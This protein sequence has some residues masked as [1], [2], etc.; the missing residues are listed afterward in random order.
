[1]NL[2]E[3]VEVRNFTLLEVLPNRHGPA[4]IEALSRM[5]AKLKYLGL[6]VRRVHSDAAGELRSTKKWCHSHGLYRTFTAGSDWMANGRAEAEIGMVRRGINVLMRLPEAEEEDWPLMARHVAER[7]GRLQLEGMGFSTPTLLPWNTQ[8]VVSTKGWDEFQGHW[9]PRKR[10]GRVRGPDMSMSLTSGGHYILLEDGKHVRASEVVEVTPE[11]ETDVSREAQKEEVEVQQTDRGVGPMSLDGRPA[12]RVGEKTAIKN[13][14]CEDLQE[15]LDRGVQFANELFKTCEGAGVEVPGSCEVVVPMVYELDRENEQLEIFIK[16]LRAAEAVAE[17]L[18]CQKAAE[19]N[20]VL[21]TKTFGLNEVRKELPKWIPALEKEVDSILSNQAVQRVSLPEAEKYMEEMRAKGHFVERVPGKAVFTQKA[22]SGRLKARICVCGNL[23]SERAAEDLYASGVDSTQVRTLVRKAAMEQWE[24]ASLDIQTAFLLAPTSQQELIVMTPP[25]ILVEAKLV[26]ADEVWIITSA[27]YGM[28][29]APRDWANY[30]D[31][32]V[33]SWRWCIED[34]DGQKCSIQFRPLGDQ[35][36]WGV[37]KKGHDKETCEG[38]AAFYVDDILMTGPKEVCD[39][40]IQQIRSVWGT[41]TPE[42]VEEGRAMKFLGIEI[43]KLR[44]GEILLHQRCYT[45]EL[46]N[47][48]GTILKSPTLKLPEEPEELPVVKTEDIRLAQAVTGELQWLANN[49]RPDIAVFVSRMA[50]L[51]TKNPRWVVEAGQA[52]LAYLAATKDQGLVYGKLEKDDADVQRRVPREAG[53]VEVMCDASF[54]VNDQHSITGIMILY[55]GGAVHWDTRKQT[56]VALSTAEAELTA[57]VD[58][59]QAG[60]SVRALVDL[61][62][63]RTTMEVANDNRAALVLGSGQ[64]GGWRT[65]HLRIRA[66]CVSEAVSNG[67]IILMH[68]PGSHLWADALTKVLPPALLERFKTG[69]KL[70]DGKLMTLDRAETANQSSEAKMRM[71]KALTAMTVAASLPKG[72]RA[73]DGSGG[74]EDR[75]SDL[76]LLMLLGGLLVIYELVKAFGIHS[77]K[78]LWV[79]EDLKVHGVSD[80]ATIPFKATEGAAGYDIATCQEATVGPGEIMLIP[81]GLCLEIPKG[82]YG[83]LM[84]R[85]SLAKTGVEVTGGVIDSDYRGE[86][87]VVIANRGQQPFRCAPGDRIAQMILLSK[88]DLKVKEC[89]QLGAT[90]RGSGSF[91]STNEAVGARPALKLASPVGHRHGELGL[92]GRDRHLLNDSGSGGQD[93]PPVMNSWGGMWCGVGD[94]DMRSLLGRTLEQIEPS[95]GRLIPNSVLEQ[96]CTP[97]EEHARVQWSHDEPDYPGLTCHL[98]K[99]PRWRLY[100]VE[101]HKVQGDP[102]AERA[103]TL[104]WMNHGGCRVILSHRLGSVRMKYIDG[105]WVGYTLFFRRPV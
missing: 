95:F 68:R 28:T 5:I 12:R 102:W 87:R 25:R 32:Q 13:L 67:E 86:V 27:L 101:S 51:T 97:P 90:I 29:T 74:R 18:E 52:A 85:S 38:T 57:L 4:L 76:A 60:R 11:V 42:F 21:Q 83:Q 33:K 63:K 89:Q 93:C 65:R 3:G 70:C 26:A 34:D 66:A 10:L 24:V 82:M 31:E 23:M 55:A 53:T 75:W 59:L 94:E 1:M 49:T 22:G 43:E 77:L 103:M 54:A 88:G 56:L 39:S 20:Q 61:F 80:Q 71:L 99:K 79:E 45:Q 9:R 37:Y 98:H 91:G 78:K 8:V 6:E 47:R 58:A 96:I 7:R 81:T 2:E 62:E 50:S 16:E 35:N 105:A 104:M 69:I 84:S 72:A 100:D 30:R 92:R 44:T 40:I 17:N 73:D 19:E 14:S 48:H 15:R 36:L 64:G 46:L 41:S